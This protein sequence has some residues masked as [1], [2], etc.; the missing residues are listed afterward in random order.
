MSPGGCFSPPPR[1]LLPLT[2]SSPSTGDCALIR[3][4]LITIILIIII[5]IL[6]FIIILLLFVDECALLIHDNKLNLSFF[7]SKT[8]RQ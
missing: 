7:K 2:T 6:L 5:I 1:H 3:I 4:T 8:S